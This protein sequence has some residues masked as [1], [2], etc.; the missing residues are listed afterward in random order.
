MFSLDHYQ[1]YH[2]KKVIVFTLHF[3]Q[4]AMAIPLLIDQH[5]IYKEPGVKLA[6]GFAA[7]RKWRTELNSGLTS[8]FVKR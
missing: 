4:I 8:Q 2:T 6:Q 5:V 3:N 7:H 1:F